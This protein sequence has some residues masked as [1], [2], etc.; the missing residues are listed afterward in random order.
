M[1]RNTMIAG[2]GLLIGLPLVMADFHELP[3]PARA[4]RMRELLEAHDYRQ[5]L[6]LW[7]GMPQRGN[8]FSRMRG[9]ML[10]TLQQRPAAEDT[11]DSIRT[12]MMLLVAPPVP[13]YLA[14]HEREISRAGGASGLHAFSQQT[15]RPAGWNRHAELAI[16][17]GALANEGRWAEILVYKPELMQMSPRRPD[18]RSLS[19]LLGFL[20]AA[21][22]ATG[23]PEEALSLFF[24]EWDLYRSQPQAAVMSQ[25]AVLPGFPEAFAPLWRAALEGVE[26]N[27]LGRRHMP[28][29][30]SPHQDSLLHIQRALMF[31]RV[32]E[33]VAASDRLAMALHENIADWTGWLDFAISASQRE[34]NP[35]RL[36]PV[37]DQLL[38]TMPEQ[39]NTWMGF[40]ARLLF[41]FQQLSPEAFAEEMRSVRDHAPALSRA[42]LEPARRVTQNRELLPAFLDLCAYLL[43]QPE[44][45]HRVRVDAMREAVPALRN[46]SNRG[47]QTEWM[48]SI[49]FPA[50]EQGWIGLDTVGPAMN[51]LRQRNQVD[52]FL[53][54]YLAA[55]RR[56]PH[57][58]LA[59]EIGRVL[60]ERHPQALELL[61]LAHAA[62]PY[63][64]VLRDALVAAYR[65]TGNEARAEALANTPLPPRPRRHIGVQFARAEEVLAAWDADEADLATAGYESLPGAEQRR[66]L[67]LVSARLR[68]HAQWL[69]D[70]PAEMTALGNWMRTLPGLDLDDWILAMKLTVKSREFNRRVNLEAAAWEDPVRQQVLFV[71]NS[72]PATVQNDHFQAWAA[73]RPRPA[74]LQAVSDL[75]AWKHW[76]DIYALPLRQALAEQ[77][78]I[79]GDDLARVIEL[80]TLQG[81][82]ARAAA[83]S[84][85]HP[86]NTHE[87]IQ[88]RGDLIR[89]FLDRGRGTMPDADYFSTL[90]QLVKTTPRTHPLWSNFSGFAPWYAVQLGAVEVALQAG[91]PDALKSAIRPAVQWI[92]EAP[93]QGMG[94]YPGL[95]VDEFLTRMLSR[96]NGPELAQAMRQVLDSI[97]AAE[98]TENLLIAR[99]WMHAAAASRDWTAI[100][101]LMT[102]WLSKT[103][104]LPQLQI[105][106]ATDWAAWAKE[107]GQE[108][109]LRQR[110]Q[111][112]NWPSAH[113]TQS[114]GLAFLHAF[115]GN[116]EAYTSLVGTP[117]N[118]KT[119][120]STM[121][122]ATWRVVALNLA[123]NWQASLQA[124]EQAAIFANPPDTPQAQRLRQQAGLY[125]GIAR[126]HLGQSDAGRRQI[127]ANAQAFTL[128]LQ[129]NSPL[130]TRLQQTPGL[131]LQAQVPGEIPPPIP[132]FGTPSPNF[133]ENA[134]IAAM[135][136]PRRPYP[137]RQQFLAHPLHPSQVSAAI[138]WARHPQNLTIT[139]ASPREWMT[140]LEA[141]AAAHPAQAAAYHHLR[142]EIFAPPQPAR[143]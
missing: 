72:H 17:L 32:P 110:L 106:F 19:P 123:G 24:V 131:I 14:E 47:E 38:E 21:K 113:P 59:A 67:E 3:F 93:R 117:E 135:L 100:S 85:N 141:L 122:V 25:V 8:E 92:V 40:R 125:A 13:D 55:Q 63:D 99:A 66:L 33:L 120:L 97:V 65:S 70:P 127:L 53:P 42:Y 10:A 20:A 101:D 29:N 7:Q 82:L 23:D 31:S 78:A 112:G 60:L 1:L 126:M 124:Y 129:P 75:I 16:T 98:P 62:R 52:N 54:R 88:L 90:E 96:P 116:Q 83:L 107:M 2:L 138:R 27:A 49:L 11:L 58:E 36:L 76:D 115:L 51:L 95:L 22:A 39:G 94:T 128:I 114:V 46:V 136:H 105:S 41:E 28:P 130:L 6:T 140:V 80:Q 81:E 102:L 68:P 45:P 84:L 134:L 15:R 12:R 61:V 103:D 56:S 121:E 118:P 37:L 50:I 69:H 5:A 48:H 89:A 64:P 35:L 143:P 86:V 87:L 119:G 132:G 108:Q 77:G 133:I 109:D 71:L 9:V 18:A 79:R 30:Q 111:R 73:T 57:P 91:H 44:I 142:T 137:Q 104:L 74:E 43:Q 34:R 26:P 4:E 139:A